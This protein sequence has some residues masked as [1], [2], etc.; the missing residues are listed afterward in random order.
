MAHAKGALVGEVHP[1]DEAPDPFAK[2]A[3]RITDELPVDVALGKLELH[4][5]CGVQRSPSDGGCLVPIA[6]FGI[7]ASGWGGTDATA[8]YAAQFAD[9]WGWIACTCVCQH[10]R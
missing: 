8:N 2:P 9:R 6:E 10:T 5:D 4:G 1:F 3:Q 7:S